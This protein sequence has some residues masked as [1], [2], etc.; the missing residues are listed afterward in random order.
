[1]A[2]CYGRG[3][4]THLPRA[5]HELQGDP[6]K[7]TSVETLNVAI[8]NTSSMLS[9]YCPASVSTY[10]EIAVSEGCTLNAEAT[11]DH[12][13]YKSWIQQF[14]P[15]KTLSMLWAWLQPLEHVEALL[16]DVEAQSISCSALPSR[17]RVRASSSS[18][19]QPT[20]KRD[21]AKRNLLHATRARLGAQGYRRIAFEPEPDERVSLRARGIV[22]KTGGDDLWVLDELSYRRRSRKE[23]AILHSTTSC[24][25]ANIQS[26]ATTTKAK[27]TNRSS[28]S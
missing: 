19:L 3:E 18:R 28:A 10:S 24:A 21:P 6:C 27:A 16:V 2:R 17:S 7:A 8:S 9:F 1:M 4:S 15:S 23:A 11:R 26:V 5:L 13:Y 20:R 14:V 25:Q 12:P 22:I